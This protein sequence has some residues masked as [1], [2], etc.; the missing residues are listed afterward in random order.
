MTTLAFE[1]A[2]LALEMAILALERV[3]TGP[4]ESDIGS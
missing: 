2:I 3:N 4:C 1:K